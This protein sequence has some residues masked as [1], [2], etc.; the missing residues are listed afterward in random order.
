M[1]PRL[2]VERRS[3][4]RLSRAQCAWLASA[5]LRPGG[6]VSILNLSPGG[7]AIDGAPRLLPGACV[8]L[9][10]A[11]PGWHATLTARV[12]RCQVAR[13]SADHGVS[14]RAALRF[15]QLFEAPFLVTQ[16]R[17]P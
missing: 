11:A 14:Y 8:D 3:A 6:E 1:S 13:L 4:R 16:A 5:R 2:R 10:L 17:A 12:L 15:D 9:H 7:T